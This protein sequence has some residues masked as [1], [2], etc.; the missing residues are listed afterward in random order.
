MLHLNLRFVFYIKYQISEWNVL[1]SNLKSIH[2]FDF[3][4]FERDSWLFNVEWSFWNAMNLKIEM[5]LYTQ[6]IIH[7]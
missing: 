2:F 5:G 1:F 7:L 6:K 4:L 3:F